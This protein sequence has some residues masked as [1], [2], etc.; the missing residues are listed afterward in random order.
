MIYL[1]MTIFLTS[2]DAITIYV[3]DD[4]IQF[5]LTFEKSYIHLVY[6]NELTKWTQFSLLN[7]SFAMKCVTETLTSRI[8]NWYAINHPRVRESIIF[9]TSCID[10]LHLLRMLKLLGIS[11]LH[12]TFV[13]LNLQYNFSTRN[14]TREWS[15]PAM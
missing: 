13:L 9:H 15:I 11:R 6:N 7:V 12:F 4:V 8:Y 5:W 3:I 14:P 1:K 2:N 10:M